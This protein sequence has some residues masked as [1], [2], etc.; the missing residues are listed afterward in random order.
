MKEIMK[1]KEKK[2]HQ[3]NKNVARNHFHKKVATFNVAKKDFEL[4]LKK[5]LYCQNEQK[6]YKL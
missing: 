6:C 5:K 4:K 3:E 2:N 1:E